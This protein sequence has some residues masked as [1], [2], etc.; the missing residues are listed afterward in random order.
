MAVAIGLMLSAGPAASA[1]AS[2]VPVI[3]GEPE[4]SIPVLPDVV[5]RIDS[6]GT[7]LIL[8]DIVP[9]THVCENFG[10]VVSG[11]RAGQ[12]VDVDYYVNSE[13]F[14]HFRARGQSFCQRVSDE[15]IVQ[16]AG[17]SQSTWMYDAPLNHLSE[18]RNVRCGRYTNHDPTCPTD[19]Y[20][21]F[22]HLAFPYYCNVNY[23][24]VRSTVILPV[25]GTTQ[26]SEDLY[27][28]YAVPPGC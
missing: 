14:G 21:S 19:R 5:Q 15:V 9:G 17:I 25:S 22:G 8:M 28:N 20:Q 3:S 26:R 2:S 12:C 4:V 23:A 6:D 7:S 11:Y 27:S 24:V 18:E 10:E 13:G 1:S 16:C